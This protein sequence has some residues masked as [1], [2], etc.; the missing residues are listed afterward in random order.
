MKNK[1][2]TRINAI[3]NL[4]LILYNNLRLSFFITI[5]LSG[6]VGLLTSMN[7][8]VKQNFFEGIEQLSNNGDLGPTIVR[9]GF[10]GIYTLITLLFQG[11]SDVLMEDLSIRVGGILGNLVNKK[12]ARIS[13][14]YY[15]DIG[16]LNL[17][18]QAYQGVDQSSKV[19][20]IA[21]A[22]A[23]YYIPYFLF[24][25]VYT[26]RIHPAL[27]M[28]ML[29]VLIPTLI[30]QNF[31]SRYYMHLENNVA[32][33]RRKMDYFRNCIAD[34][35]YARE[36]RVLGAIKYFRSLYLSAVYQFKEK[37]W[38]AEKKSSFIELALRS[39][40]LGAYVIIL[41]IMFYFTKKNILS[42][43][44]FVAILSSID[45]MFNFMD[46]VGNNIGDISS[47]LPSVVNTW[48]FLCLPEETGKEVEIKNTNIRLKNV[49]FCYPCS[50]KMVLKNVSLSIDE[51][52]TVAIVGANGAGKST[53][54]KIILGIYK[55]T[56]GEMYI[57]NSNVSGISRKSNHKLCS[58]V[59]QDFQK[60]KMTLRQNVQI[61]ELERQ[62]DDSIILENLRNVG[63]NMEEGAY[64]EGLGTLLTREFGGT[65]ISGG[66]WQRIAIARGIY[67]DHQIIVLD[68][69]TASIDPLE[70]S[71][72]YKQFSELSKGKTSLIITHRIGSA[73]IANRVIVMD[74]G[75][76]VEIGSHEELIKRCELYRTMYNS[77]AGWYQ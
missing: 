1:K 23:S 51:G 30:V 20:R 34:R 50:N 49:S 35:E 56:E 74:K 22:L 7:V 77:Q 11:H 15:E 27:S 75:E 60:Y 31:R 21:T 14:L 5:L 24:F 37:S 71:K 25:T 52:E 68:E 67:R 40:S 63:I 29:L 61:S 12:A 62:S 54:V 13:P 55:P 42:I 18:N 44:A 48:T 16:V 4:S 58:A 2:C 28:I 43:A 69:P 33:L 47:F 32:P 53:M 17:I 6:L 8:L 39:I 10:W 3:Y 38:K 36:T 72:I 26:Y 66:Q 70:E 19:I 41:L 76:V 46:Y 45:Q 65:D 64:S 9:G 57:G 73:K 59:F